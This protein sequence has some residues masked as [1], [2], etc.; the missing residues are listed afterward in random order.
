MS[1]YFHIEKNDFKYGEIEKTKKW[2]GDVIK[3]EGKKEGEI[4]IIFVDDEKIL[5]LNKTYLSHNY[6]TDVIAF[7]Y[8]KGNWI[9]GDIYVSIDTVKTNSNKYLTPLQEE[10][11]RA[12]VHGLL[13]LLDYDDKSKHQKENMREKE[14]LYLS[15]Y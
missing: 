12:I 2:L 14:A 8:N 7:N 3:G 11:Q 4:S 5:Q 13:H 1:I 10:L 15:K 9:S 6:F